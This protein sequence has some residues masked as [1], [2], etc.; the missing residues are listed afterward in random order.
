MIIPS[1]R[2]WEAVEHLW[3]T[4]VSLGSPPL[5]SSNSVLNLWP[6]EGRLYVGHGEWTTNLGPTDV[7]SV[8]P[9]GD[10]V[11]HL[12]NAPTEAFNVFREIDGWLYAPYTDPK[13]MGFGGY[14][15]NEGG[16]WRAV[17]MNLSM[18][19]TFDVAKTRH[20]LWMTGSARSIDGLTTE[21]VVV[22]STDGGATWA[23]VKVGHR[24]PLGRYYGIWVEGDTVFVRHSDD[25]LPVEASS[26][27]GAT[28]A[29]VNR[30][31]LHGSLT[32]IGYHRP[33]YARTPTPTPAQQVLRDWRSGTPEL[34]SDPVVLDEKA[35]CIVRTTPVTILRRPAP[36]TN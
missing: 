6:Y 31:D 34:S 14:A 30:P 8:G 26:D 33:D 23:E 7:L 18:V 21:P 22:L 35:Y 13:G 11:T 12:E 24:A 17:T 3:S 5:P 32:S 25:S 29:Q 1:A 4:F 27:G 20:G 2:R 28:W 36:P 9:E 19:H 15:T 10:V 16:E